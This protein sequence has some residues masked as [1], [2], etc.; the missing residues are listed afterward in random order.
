MFSQE[1]TYIIA[2]INRK[3]NYPALEWARQ[4]FDILSLTVCSTGTRNGIGFDAP[5]N[6]MDRSRYLSNN[7]DAIPRCFQENSRSEGARNDLSI[8]DRPFPALT[9]HKKRNGREGMVFFIIDF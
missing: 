2:L 6:E 5:R 1:T 9:A 7:P 8:S 3:L 4:T